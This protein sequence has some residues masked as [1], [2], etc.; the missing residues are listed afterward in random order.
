MRTISINS[1]TDVDGVLANWR[2]TLE[3]LTV[4]TY[5]GLTLALVT[6]DCSSSG[7]RTVSL[8]ITSDM[9]DVYL[10]VV[11]IVLL[12]N[13]VSAWLTLPSDLCVCVCVC[14]L[15]GLACCGLVY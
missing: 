14:V 13:V 2:D 4:I 9:N 8:P 5:Q 6:E 7:L 10:S 1:F 12:V 11:A 3:Y 15:E